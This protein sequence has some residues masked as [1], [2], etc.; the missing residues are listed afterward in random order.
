MVSTNDN[1][2]NSYSYWVLVNGVPRAGFADC[3]GLDGS[4][5]AKNG[6][7]VTLRMGAIAA[8]E[9]YDWVMRHSMPQGLRVLQRDENGLPQRAWELA[10]ARV[11]KVTATTFTKIGFPFRVEAIEL[12]VDGIAEGQNF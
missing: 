6:L 1:P 11:V 8:N 9:F 3:Y 4:V 5:R 7:L 10:E 12:A 2:L